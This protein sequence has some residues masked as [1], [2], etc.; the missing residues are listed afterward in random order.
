[1]KKSLEN[2]FAS[3]IIP[4]QRTSMLYEVFSLRGGVARSLRYPPAQAPGHFSSSPYI[5]HTLSRARTLFIPK[6]YMDT[7]YRP[8]LAPAFKDKGYDL[9]N[10]RKVRFR[11]SSGPGRSRFTVSLQKTTDQILDI[12]SSTLCS[13]LQAKATSF[14]DVSTICSRLLVFISSI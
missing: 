7:C 4:P 2:P 12:L 11:R 3:S 1:M 14:S 10:G 13:R 6:H 5:V 9:R 8:Q